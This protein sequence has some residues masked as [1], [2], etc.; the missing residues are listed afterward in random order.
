MV[1]KKLSC[2]AIA[3]IIAGAVILVGMTIGLSVYFANKGNH[4]NETRSDHETRPPGVGAAGAGA[5]GAGRAKTVAE[6]MRQAFPA[7]YDK[8]E[9]VHCSGAVNKNQCAAAFGGAQKRRWQFEKVY[10]EGEFRKN[11]TMLSPKD[12]KFYQNPTASKHKH[13]LAQAA[14]N[15]S[16]FITGMPYPGQEA[17]GGGNNTGAPPNYLHKRQN[18]GA[19]WTVRHVPT[20]ALT[21]FLLRKNSPKVWQQMLAY[22]QVGEESFVR[23]WLFAPIFKAALRVDEGNGSFKVSA[24]LPPADLNHAKGTSPVLQ[25]LPDMLWE[26]N[27]DLVNKVSKVSDMYSGIA[28][29][30][31]PASARG[32]AAGLRLPEGS[33]KLATGEL[34][35]WFEKL[36]TKAFLYGQR[37]ENHHALLDIIFDLTPASPPKD[38]QKAKRFIERLASYSGH[39][40]DYANW[41]IPDGSPGQSWKNSDWDF[42]NGKLQEG[43]LQEVECQ[44]FHL[45]HF[46]DH[47]RIGVK[48]FGH[49]M[50]GMN[51]GTPLRANGNWTTRFFHRLLAGVHDD[52]VATKVKADLFDFR[53]TSPYSHTVTQLFLS[54]QSI[55]FANHGVFQRSYSPELW[56]VEK[57]AD[58]GKLPGWFRSQREKDP[59]SVFNTLGAVFGRHHKAGK[60][61][62]D[63]AQASADT[64]WHAE[65][66]Q[67]TVGK[68]AVFDRWRAMLKKS[69]IFATPASLQK[70]FNAGEAGGKKKK[71][72]AYMQSVLAAG[73]PEKAADKLA[74]DFEEF[75]RKYMWL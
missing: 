27:S 69:S 24:Q 74:S 64:D 28:D 36:L 8:I 25:I 20:Q 34:N 9:Q 4:D 57:S 70:A 23:A 2:F 37:S 68:A 66:W 65:I 35:G 39:G 52:Q 21:L 44:L 1:C 26:Q 75:A 18:H 60:K 55:L 58:D 49:L 13:W 5:A 41:K 32:D 62:F 43:Q 73:P 51:N 30:S 16:T 3:L 19:L 46:L 47:I 45:P 22:S 63:A 48:G 17:K 61:A 10:S 6:Y 59:A 15:L 42:R 71:I 11:P 50:Q 33:G 14:K 67:K 12:A 54:F 53:L 72:P 56:H 40:C 31:G 29:A 7:D 38:R